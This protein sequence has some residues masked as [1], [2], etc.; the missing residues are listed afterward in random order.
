MKH[1]AT[2]AALVLLA[3]CGE[4]PKHLLKEDYQHGKAAFEMLE[5]FDKA[6]DEPFPHGPKY[7]P[8]LLSAAE[9]MD[10]INAKNSKNGLLNAL[11][12]YEEAI[13][14]RISARYALASA[15][16]KVEIAEAKPDNDASLHALR[17]KRS[18]ASLAVYEIEPIIK[19]CH[20]DAAQ[21]FYPSAANTNTCHSELTAFKTKYPMP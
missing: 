14:E 4:G 19:L 3:G 20:D 17:Q 6:S 5:Q 9:Q 8:F 16:T 15:T 1:R 18:E 2:F 12:G 11:D 10:H 13:S 7:G 21:Y